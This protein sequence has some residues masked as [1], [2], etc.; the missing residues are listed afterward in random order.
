MVTVYEMQC[1]LLKLALKIAVSVMHWCSLE[2]Y[3]YLSYTTINLYNREILYVSET[4]VNSEALM[5]IVYLFSID[6][7]FHFL[8]VYRLMMNSSIGI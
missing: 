5:L 2:K 1:L 7:N 3:L 4:T 8:P 6:Y